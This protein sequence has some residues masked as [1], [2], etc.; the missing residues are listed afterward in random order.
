MFPEIRNLGEAASREVDDSINVRHRVARTS[1]TVR[2]LPPALRRTRSVRFTSS[3]GVPMKQIK[4]P[5]VSVV[6]GILFLTAVAVWAQCATQEQR[7]NEQLNEIEQQLRQSNWEPAR[8]GAQF[9]TESLAERGGGT[10]ADHRDHADE[11]NG[12]MAGPDPSAEEL[13][14]GRAAALGA[15][16]EAELGRRD[17]ARWHWY[18]AQNLSRNPRSM[19][20]SPYGEAGEFLRQNLLVDAEPQHAGIMDVLD[21]VRPEGSERSGFQPPERINVTYPRRPQDR[22]GRDRFSHVVFIQITVD[23]TGQVTQ[24]LV[25]DGGFY[26][27]LI[28]RAFEALRTWKYQPATLRGKPIPFRYVVPVVFADDRPE[29]PGVSF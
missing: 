10:I 12:A 28:Y 14:L 25:V 2:L 1:D 20:L 4:S 11:L 23:A 15:I 24:P 26:P 21:P 19:D 3:L 5:V 16:A 7:W 17:E 29:H 27:G 6:S 9:L 22:R 8:Q 18:L 13:A